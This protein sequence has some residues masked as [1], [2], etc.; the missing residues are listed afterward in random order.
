MG[1]G[2]GN[3]RGTNL[4]GYLSGGGDPMVFLHR[5]GSSL[6]RRSKLRMRR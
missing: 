2:E 3:E 4:G 5:S 6:G 1:K